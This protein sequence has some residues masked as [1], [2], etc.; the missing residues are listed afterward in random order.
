VTLLWED[1]IDVHS[2]GYVVSAGGVPGTP[3]NGF[4]DA[5]WEID[6]ATGTVQL[7]NSDGVTKVYS[8]AA[9]SGANGTTQRAEV[10]PDYKA[11]TS[12][13]DEIWM[14]FDFE[15][16]VWPTAGDWGPLAFQFHRVPPGNGT[17]SFEPGHGAGGGMALVGASGQPGL[18]GTSV[19]ELGARPAPG[20]KTR[21]VVG[22]F[23]HATNG[24]VEAWRDGVQQGA[25]VEPWAAEDTSID[26]PGDST[27]TL[28]PAGLQGWK[29]GVYRDR[30]G[31][32]E[33][34]YSNLLLATSRGEVLEPL[35]P[36]GATPHIVRQNVFEGGAD[37]VTI[38]TG[39]S[40]GASLDAFN[41][42]TGTTMT[43]S[44][45]KAANDLR[46]AKFAQSGTFAAKKLTWTS[47]GII[48]AP[49]DV[50]TRFYLWIPSIP[51]AGPVE[52]SRY[53]TAADAQSCW[54]ALVNT[55]GML[56]FQNAGGSSIAASLGTVACPTSQWFRV[57]TRT[58][59]DTTAGE[60]EW[61]RYDNPHSLTL[62]DTGIGVAQVLAASCDRISFGMGNSGPTSVDWYYDS[63]AISDENWLGPKDLEA[64]AY[65]FSLNPKLRLRSGA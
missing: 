37:G 38:T 49:D 6:T 2:V 57:E 47:L 21:I 56:R 12:S 28:P 19:I 36:G 41:V 17:V 26:G 14:G 58:R 16:P 63:L 27:S 61:R 5:N 33:F 39:N 60:V 15:I 46:S 53:A 62:S 31:A 18:N 20:T 48:A 11:Y 40:G 34:Q 35:G 59:H 24:W 65:D 55:T 3:L 23:V 64:F 10:L 7:A 29:F 54:L 1:H 44:S 51:S 22:V 4:D 13:G 43:F 30:S 50:F 45:A 25:R 42:V 9:A 8:S 32:I 52:L